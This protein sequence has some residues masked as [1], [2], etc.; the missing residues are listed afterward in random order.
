M[1]SR[2]ALCFLCLLSIH[3]CCMA[4]Y[5][6]EISEQELQN[7]IS[8]M[9]PKEMNKWFLK[10]TLSNPIVDLSQSVNELCVIS[11]VDIVAPGGLANSGD[12]RL[13]GTLIY[14]KNSGAFFL[15]SPKILD[16]RIAGISSEN[17]SKMKGLV[18]IFAEKI[19]SAH[20]VYVLKS[21]SIKSSIAKSF[22]RTVEVKEKKLILLFELFS[23]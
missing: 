20:P 22:L 12:V 4:G 10:T 7:K 13:C 6:M 11:D 16:I 1:F 18:Q 19:F 23:S 5:S 17:L 15:R 2:K 8:A 3:F 9:M 21:D 14:E